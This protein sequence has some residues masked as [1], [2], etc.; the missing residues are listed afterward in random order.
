MASSIPGV[1][2]KFITDSIIAGSNWITLIIIFGLVLAIVAF[3]GIYYIL[4]RSYNIHVLIRDLTGD[5][6]IISMDKAKYF[7]DKDGHTWL[8]LLN[9][10]VKSKKLVPI[11]DPSCYNILSKGQKFLEVTRSQNGGY[12]FLKAPLVRE[13]PRDLLSDV[14]QEILNI[15]DI[16]DRMTK[17][18]AWKSNKI[19]EF[20]KSSQADFVFDVFSS[21]QRSAQVANIRKAEERR[22]TNWMQNLPTIAALSAFVIIIV[23]LL[24]FLPKPVL[25]AQKLQLQQNEMQLEQVKILKEIKDNV[26]IFNANNQAKIPNILTKPNSTG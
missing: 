10:K 8:K 24:I 23:C 16:Q 11:P 22:K 14:P 19:S 15:E 13:M 17:T 6:N 9:E 26:Q 1:D 25:E 18:Q 5:G 21:E 7:E 20:K 4:R 3:L 12:N 2:F